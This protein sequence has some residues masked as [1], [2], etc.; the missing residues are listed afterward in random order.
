MTAEHMM[1]M[2]EGEYIEL[3]KGGTCKSP[4]HVW[5]QGDVFIEPRQDF[6]GTIDLRIF[7][8]AF[9]F[10]TFSKFSFSNKVLA[11]FQICLFSDFD[12]CGFFDFSIC[13][14]LTF[15]FSN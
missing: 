11:G 15:R 8:A 6:S 12:F 10:R 5:E 1:L 4:I 2:K 13:R 9:S 14:V 3:Y 7:F